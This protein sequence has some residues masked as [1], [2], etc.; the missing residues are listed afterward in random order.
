M[1][2]HRVTHLRA[3]RAEGEPRHSHV[4]GVETVEPAGETRAWRLVQFVE[5]IRRGERFYLD[6]ATGQ[7]EVVPTVCDHCNSVTITTAPRR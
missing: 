6:R 4:V 2:G 1:L 7:V 5:A 3:D